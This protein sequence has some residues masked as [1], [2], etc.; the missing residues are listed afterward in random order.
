M[1]Y[2]K[3]FNEAKEKSVV[4]PELRHWQGQV[5]NCPKGSSVSDILAMFAGDTMLRLAYP[6]VFMAL[7]LLA[8]LPVTTASVE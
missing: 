8:T 7:K 3:F 6:T 5:Q 2:G 4:E 1:K